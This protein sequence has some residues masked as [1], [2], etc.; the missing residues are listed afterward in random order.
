MQISFIGLNL[1]VIGNQLDGLQKL[2]LIV[3]LVGLLEAFTF[4]LSGSNFRAA[5][6]GA[7]NYAFTPSLGITSLLNVRLSGQIIT[8]L[9]T[10]N[11]VPAQTVGYILN[12]AGHDRTLFRVTSGT[13]LRVGYH[14]YQSTPV[15]GSLTQST[16]TQ[17]IKLRYSGGQAYENI[18]DG[19]VFEEI[20][21][22]AKVLPDL[23]SAGS[24]DNKIAKF[25]GDVL[26]WEADID[27]TP[28]TKLLPDLPS[29]GSRDNK[30]PK[31]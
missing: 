14:V 26:G 1:Q 4:T 12:V 17:T 27:T 8:R 23:P 13:D 31:F 20:P 25:D 19:N 9:E 15:T 7:L 24:R 30:I 5:A 28:V 11:T 22:A 21:T 6:G 18:H 16:H 3:L 2:L 10:V 29:T